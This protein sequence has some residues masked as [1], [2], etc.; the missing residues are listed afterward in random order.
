MRNENCKCLWY[1]VIEKW[2]EYGITEMETKLCK[3]KDL[4]IGK[5]IE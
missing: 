3:N 4:N 2:N 1:T 5:R